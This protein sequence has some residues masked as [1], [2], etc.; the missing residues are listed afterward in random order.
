MVAIDSSAPAAP[1]RCPVIDLVAVSTGW[2]PMTARRPAISA[3][4]PTGVE[5][6]CA[7]TCTMSAPVR[8]ASRSALRDR[9]D[10][11][12]AL[13]V[14][15]HDVVPV[16]GDAGAGEPGVDPGAAGGGV[17]GPLEHDDGRALAEH[18][19]VAA[20][21]PR[22]GRPAP[23]S[24]LRVDMARIEAKPAIGSGWMTASVPPAMTTSARPERMMSRPSAMASAPVAQALATQWT[25]ALAPSS[26]PTKAAG[27]LGM[28]IG[29]V[30]G[31]DPPGPAGLQDVVLGEQGLRAADAGADADR[32]PLRV[33]AR[34]R[35]GPASAQACCGGDERHRLGPVEPAQPD[36]VEHLGRVDRELRGDPDRQL[37]GPLLGQGADTPE[38]PA[39]MASQ[40]DATSP[41][42]GVV[43]PSPVTTTSGRVTSRPGRLRRSSVM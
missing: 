11:A 34:R 8:P 24:S 38:R 25:P 41:P 32:E 42:S 31:R 2:S 17:V 19:A 37:L 10:E 3:M 27:P 40:V 35:P 1:S 4:S 9:P 18:E 22:A 36:P 14:R 28:S 12:G 23:G 30:C 13:G 21:V 39:S 7:L 16:R 33:D 43:A 20:L 15:L 6:A 29:T 5:V 26:S